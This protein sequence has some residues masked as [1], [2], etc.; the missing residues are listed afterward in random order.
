MDPVHDDPFAAVLELGTEGRGFRW[1]ALAGT[2]LFHSVVV[3]FAAT[4]LVGLAEFARDIQG[5]VRARLRT[6]YDFMVDRS[7][8]R[9]R[10]PE[11]PK[12][13][14]VP[15]KAVRFAPNAA[16]PPPPVAA[17]PNLMDL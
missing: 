8:P 17:A 9:P 13:E 15:P 1:F 2:L 10:A 7:R 3:G 4:S 16:P 5:D 12:P 11:P 6:Q 14:P